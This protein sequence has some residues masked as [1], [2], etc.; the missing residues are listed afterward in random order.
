M[1]ENTGTKKILLS[2]LAFAI[3]FSSFYILDFKAAQSKIQTNSRVS[4]YSS[5]DPM[6]NFPGKI[7]LYVEGDDSISKSFRESL[8]AELEKAGMK[9]SIAGA[10]E[11]KYDSQAL[12]VNVSKDGLYTPFYASSDLKLLFFYTSTGEDTKYF[13]QFKERNEPVIF[14]NKGSGEGEKLI[15]GDMNLQDSTKGL[16]SLKA[17]RKYLAE[18]AAKET[19]EQLQQQINLSP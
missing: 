16:V 15:H 6:I 7:Y 12:L 13:E 5:G 11:E 17:Y 14:E 2:I 8:K 18:E 19:V 1:A 10:V 9:V 4:A 3:V